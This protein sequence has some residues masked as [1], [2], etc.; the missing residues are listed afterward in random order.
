MGLLDDEELATMEG[1]LEKNQEESP[2]LVSQWLRVESIAVPLAARTRRSVIAT[3]SE[4]AM[5]A[6]ILWDADK[7]TAAVTAREDLQSTAMDNGVALLHPRRPLPSILGDNLLALGRTGQGIPFGG[8]KS[9]TDIFFLVCSLDDRSHLRVLARIARLISS[10]G[11]LDE[12][13]AAS[14]ATS[15][16]DLICEAEQN[17]S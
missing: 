4:L 9:L 12:I 5:Q 14:D 10:E 15:V 17:L 6:G 8:S 2:V 16:Y 3:M 1:R 11:L 13:R 7:M